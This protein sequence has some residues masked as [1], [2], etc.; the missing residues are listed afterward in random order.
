MRTVHRHL[1]PAIRR[2]RHARGWQLPPAHMEERIRA[3]A[4]YAASRTK[5][6]DDFF[7]AASAHGIAQAVILAA[8]LD[9]R[10]WRLPWGRRQRGLRDRPAEGARVQ[11]RDA[12]PTTSPLLATSRCPS[13][14]ARTGRRPCATRVST[15]QSRPRGPPRACCRTCPPRAR[16]CCSS[17]SMNSARRAAG[18]AS[19]HSAPGSSIPSTWRADANS[20]ARCGEAAGDRRHRSPRRRR[21]LVHRGSHRRRRLADGARLAGVV[22]GLPAR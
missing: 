14:F 3:I 8:G 21:P 18:S 11:G 9:A 10:A 13:T 15:L 19:N 5:W 17:A 22:R 7:V 1:R 20:C 2:R 6:F 16:T 12:A 4:N